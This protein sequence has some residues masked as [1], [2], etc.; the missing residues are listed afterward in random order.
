[1][2]NP[3]ASFENGEFPKSDFSELFKQSFLEGQLS[4]PLEKK[5]ST[6]G[7]I[8]SKKQLAWDTLTKMESIWERYQKILKEKNNCELFKE[9]A[10]TLLNNFETSRDTILKNIYESVSSEFTKFYKELHSDDEGD[11]SSR[12]LSD[13]ARLVFEVDFYGRGMFPPHALH[14][15]GHQDSMGICL[16]FALNKYLTKGEMNIIILDDV[17]MSIDRVHRK[18]V[19][20]LLGGCFSEKQFIITTHDESW[21]KQLKSGGIVKQKRMYHFTNWDIDTGP[22]VEFD[23]NF[24]NKIRGDL[25]NDDAPSASHRLRRE[26]ECFFEMV[27]D[28][29]GAQITYKGNHDWNLGE[30]LPSAVASLKSNLRKAKDN[31]KKMGMKEKVDELNELDKKIGQVVE[32]TQHEQWVINPNVHFTKWEEYQ[33]EDLECVV[34]AFKELFDVFIC[35]DCHSMI[36]IKGG[37]GEKMLSCKCGKISWNVN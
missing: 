11:F 33:K 4:S 37:K 13:K 25:E 22:S 36:S 6:H 8:Y 21:A 34:D 28:L 14:S 3:I 12:I 32:K 17:I 10:D 31:Y 26:S 15:E 1:M 9:R 35:E 18:K 24:W 23:V 30:Y 16:F 27:C 29:L 2:T 7:E 20:N 5:M 19:C